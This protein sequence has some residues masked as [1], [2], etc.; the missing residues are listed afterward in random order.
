MDITK[1]AAEP[2]LRFVVRLNTDRF[3]RFAK[4][5]K[6]GEPMMDLTPNRDRAWFYLSKTSASRVANALKRHGY[7]EATVEEYVQ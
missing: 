4:L 6:H 1:A 7:T 2:A 3:I 5:V